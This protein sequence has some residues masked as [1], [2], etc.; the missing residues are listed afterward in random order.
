MAVDTDRAT[1][2]DF[3]GGCPVRDTWSVAGM[4]LTA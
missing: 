1:A 2:E 4:L 3:A